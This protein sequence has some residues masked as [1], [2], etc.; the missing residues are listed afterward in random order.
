MTIYPRQL[1][2]GVYE[3]RFC[4]FILLEVIIKKIT[5]QAVDW[6]VEGLSGNSLYLPLNFAVNLKLFA[7]K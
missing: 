1:F 6:C 5:R 3:K 7:P 2:H 4:L